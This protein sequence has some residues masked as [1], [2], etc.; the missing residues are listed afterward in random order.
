MPYDLRTHRTRGSRTESTVR[1]RTRIIDIAPARPARAWSRLDTVLLLLITLGA[2]VLRFASLG[3]PIE[4]VFDEIF[5]ARDA[6]W[7]IYGSESVCDI[8]GLAS[9]AHPPLGKWLIGSGIA[10]FGYEPFGWRVAAAL[11]GTITVVLVYVLGRRLLG[12]AVSP[13]AASV[14]AAAAAFLLAIDFLH[15]VQSRIG[16]LDAFIVLFVV[17]AVLA[18]VLDRDRDREA[19]ERWWRRLT[20][21]RPWRLVAGIFLGAATATKWSG[22]YVAPAVIGLVVAWEIA[23]RRRREPNAG[24]SRWILGAVRREAIPT[25]ILLG[26]VPLIVYVASYTGRMPGELFA[27]PW[28]PASVW[29]GI[30]QHQRAML[31]FHTELGGDHPYQS[32]PWSWIL[33]KRP[34]AYWF[35]DDGGTYREILALGNPLVWWPALLALIGLVVTWWRAGFRILRPEPVILAAAASTFLPWLVLSGGRSQTFIWY[36]LPTV[37]FL[38][39]ALAFF[40]AW[41]WS[42]LRWR[43]VGAVYALVI[44]ASFGFFLPLLTAL[45][46]SPDAWRSHMLFTDCAGQTLP[47]DTTSS[48]DPPP[49]WC[50][51]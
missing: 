41:A 15:L 20:L 50:W 18:I 40:A 13:T 9:R 26:I 38:C 14:G 37:P 47:D 28:D 43:V 8:A 19:P 35:S 45:P 34:V 17:A 30:W 39:L 48:G 49:G 23:E 32:P 31:D 25:A 33:L 7:Y 1:T 29:N 10:V 21:G 27:A 2:A 5:Y 12:G 51:I 11:A 22:A 46:L 44:L 16:M 24:W 3:R 42:R 36:L 6:C 4:L